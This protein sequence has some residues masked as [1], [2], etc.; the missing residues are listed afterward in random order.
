MAIKIGSLL[1]S[2]FGEIRR[3]TRKGEIVRDRM[4][5]GA[6]LRLKYGFKCYEIGQLINRSHCT[7]HHYCKTFFTDCND[8]DFLKEALAMEE[9][10]NWFYP[11]KGNLVVD[12]NPIKTHYRDYRIR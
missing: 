8:P 4:I 5:L 6:F 3:R 12:S 10:L 9:K 11:G 2:S 7:I 1:Q